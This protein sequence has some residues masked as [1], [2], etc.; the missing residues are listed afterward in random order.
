MQRD[1]EKGRPAG[2]APLLRLDA[3]D[4]QTCRPIHPSRLPHQASMELTNETESGMFPSSAERYIKMSVMSNGGA[5][6]LL[7]PTFNLFMCEKKEEDA[8]I[9]LQRWMDGF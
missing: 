5:A 9:P 3:T 7:Y 1:A 8:F 4:Y 2:G 6:H